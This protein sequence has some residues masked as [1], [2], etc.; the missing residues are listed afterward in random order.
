MSEK[1]KVGWARSL[2]E[3]AWA[4]ATRAG[5][6]IAVGGDFNL[7]PAGVKKAQL[8]KLV[9]SGAVFEEVKYDLSPRRAAANKEKIDWLFLLSPRGCTRRL[10]VRPCTAARVIDPAEPHRRVAEVHA[11]FFD[12]D[13]IIVD[14]ALAVRWD[15]V[16]EQ[17]TVRIQAAARGHAA[18]ERAKA[19][20]AAAR[21]EAAIQTE[22]AARVV[23]L[24]FR[25]VWEH[26]ALTWDLAL[27]WEEPWVCA[28]RRL[29]YVT[30]HIDFGDVRGEDRSSYHRRRHSPSSTS[31]TAGPKRRRSG[32]R[33]SRS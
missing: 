21:T 14:L 16:K 10:E 24:K 3:L 28:R 17:T 23:D 7:K 20:A 12:H 2:F 1:E 31:T 30:R 29:F 11:E 33:S 32:T 19:L 15:V 5:A 13:A 6:P 4:L 18:R 26:P 25:V 9:P 27:L 8:D 22:A